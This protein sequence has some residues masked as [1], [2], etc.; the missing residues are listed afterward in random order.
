MVN[1]SGK[2]VGRDSRVPRFTFRERHEEQ[3]E[4]L[5][6]NP[7]LRRFKESRGRLAA[8]PHRPVYHFTSPECPMHDPN[9]LC[10]WRGRWHLFYQALPPEEPDR[11]HWGHAVS[12]DLVHWRD[13]PYALFPDREE[14]CFSGNTWVE[15]D[16]V[17][18]HYHGRGGACGNYLAVSRDPLLL[19]WEKLPGQ[20]AIAADPPPAGLCSHQVFDPFLWRAKGAYYSISGTRALNPAT[21]LPHRAHPLFRSRDLVD[22]QY[23][24]EFVENDHFSMNGDTGHC[25]YFLSLGDRHILIHFGSLGGARYLL[26]DYDEARDKFIATS[27]GCFN[28]GPR[29]FGAVH[30]PS[31]C[32]DGRGGVIVIFNMNNGFPVTNVWRDLMTLP[33]RLALLGGD[34]VAVE[35]AGDIRALRKSPAVVSNLRLPANHEVVLDGVAGNSMELELEIDLK[36]AVYVEL[37]VL[38]APDMSEFTRIRFFRNSGYPKPPGRPCDSLWYDREVHSLIGIDASRSSISPDLLGIKAPETAPL[39]LKP[40]EPLRLRVFI[41][42]S[43]VEVFANGRQCM[44][45]RVYPVLPHSLGV[46]LLSRGRDAVLSLLASYPMEK[47]W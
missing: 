7:L 23:L 16:R 15:E 37:N 42:R 46:S 22:W 44:A 32:A 1:A 34:D 5:Q 21:G 35:P 10:H 13:L 17:I 27:G 43:V 19:N 9:G 26:G 28:F 40:E 6:E 12:E 41:D 29:R 33:R 3:E 45:Q 14:R 2:P 38:R 25:P 31:A 8:D 20:P 18:A 39:Y 30:A 36:D 11:Q 47:L 4:Q 24:H